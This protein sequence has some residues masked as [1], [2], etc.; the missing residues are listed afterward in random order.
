MSDR[1]SMAW[2][3]LRLSCA[4]IFL[5]FGTAPS[6][7]A[8]DVQSFSQWFRYAPS[9]MNEWVISGSNTDP[10]RVELHRK[11]SEG[12]PKK[13]FVLYPRPSSAYDTA[14]T[15]ILRV[16]AV[17]EIN[18]DLTVVNFEVNDALAKAALDEAQR[19]KAELI[20]AMGSESTDWLYKHYR[21]GSIPIVTVCSKDPV[22]LGQMKDYETGSGNNFAFTSLNVPVE[23]QMAYVEELRPNLKNLA[24]L[25]D[26]KNISAVKTQAEPIANYAKHKGVQVIWGSVANPDNA[27]E[28]L[29]RIIPSAVSAMR[30]TDP[31]LSESLFWITGSTSVFREIHTINQYSGKVPVVSVVPEI[32]TQG[33]DSAVLAIGVSFE[34]NAQLAAVYATRILRGVSP[35]EL[36]VGIVSPPDIAISFLKAHQ[37]GMRVPFDFFEIAGF[38]YDYEGRAVR[39]AN[40]AEPAASQ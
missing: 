8:S 31:D 7:L 15:E 6:A 30:K 28:E 16:F 12:S 34:S 17:K 33:E 22:Q 25:V 2:S 5:I 24:V 32:V 9:I 19:T 26:S 10:L 40:K 39:V 18:A 29:A 1:I 35:G 23:V 21:G 27:R 3:R 37:I 36:K 14:I 11:D 13:V 4:A 38:V 20:I